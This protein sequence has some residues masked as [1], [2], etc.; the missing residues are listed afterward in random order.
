MS[1]A[2][3][4]LTITN[5][6]PIRNQE[7][8]D[9]K[10]RSVYWLTDEDSKRII[11]EY[12]FAKQPFDI[13]QDSTLGIMI[14]S[15]RISA[16]DV[17]WQSEKLAGIPGKG[18]YLNAISNYWFNLFEEKLNIDNHLLDDPH[19]QVWLVQKAEPIKIEAIA[20]EYITGS[21]WRAYNSGERIFCGMKLPND[22][23]KNQN[24]GAIHLTPT[25]KGSLAIKGLPSGEDANLTRDQITLNWEKLGFKSLSDVLNC[26]EMLIKG[27]EL[28]RDYLFNEN[29]ILVDT[30]LEFGYVRYNNGN[31]NM[32]IIDEVITPDSSRLWDLENH[33]KGKYVENSKEP[34]RDFL[35]TKSGLEANVLLN[36]QRMDERRKLAAEYKVPTEVFMEVS[37]TYRNIAR[38]ITNITDPAQGVENPREEIIQTL[39][40]NYEIII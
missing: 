19:P 38:K 13:H 32:I 25:T 15:D 11:E 2:D 28:A 20:R 3:E 34:F 12:G 23:E 33:N 26:E 10:V 29:E 21:M 30:K 17:N 40:D 31:S 16:F 39:S 1:L 36:S 7:I 5:D 6:F 9:G 8:H 37:D 35:L 18:V 4:V 27:F 24:L 14:T 22:L